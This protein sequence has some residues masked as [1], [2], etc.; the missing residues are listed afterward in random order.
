MYPHQIRLRG[1]W[2]C[3]PLARLAFDAHGSTQEADGPV[4]AKRR[5]T[6]PCRWGEGGLGDFSGRV[7]F[8]R[9]F[10]WLAN[11][12]HHERVW[13]TF[14]GVDGSAE[15]CLNGRLLGTHRDPVASF[16]FEVSSL[17]QPRNEL[18]VV[19]EASGGSGGLWG[20]VALEV[21]CSA[22]L[23]DVRWWLSSAG[24]RAILHVS[25]EVVGAADRPLE[26]Y[27]LI[28]GSTAIYSTVKPTP[29]GQSFSL[30][31][32][33][34]DLLSRPGQSLKAAREHAIRIELVNGAV[35]WYCIEGIIDATK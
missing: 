34:V 25:G 26:L 7:R 30:T 3:E 19:V 31:S 2:E 28:D 4:P 33:P 20:E 6:I 27:A 15:V 11:I 32:E 35:P 5:V 23:R 13:L 9:R 1:P 29:A 8:N 16:E 18:T 17:L 24:D 14:G 12:A 10:G 21:R 22:Y